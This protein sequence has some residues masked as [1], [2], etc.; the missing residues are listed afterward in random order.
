MKNSLKSLPQ[1]SFWL[2]LCIGFFISFSS[3][4]PENE[5]SIESDYGVFIGADSMNEKFYNYKIL[6][7][8]AANFT[9]ADLSLLHKKGIEVYS[10]LN[11]GSIENFR[12]YYSRF[13]PITLGPYENWPEERWVDLSRQEWQNYLIDTIAKSLV[14]KGIDGFFIDNLDIY[15]LFH[16]DHIF[17]GI[18]AILSGLRQSFPSKSILLNGGFDYTHALVQ[19]N[20]K[21]KKNKLLQDLA[22]GVNQECVFSSINFSQNLLTENSSKERKEMLDYLSFI[23]S[24][25]LEVYVIEYTRS[26]KLIKKIQNTFQEKGYSYYVTDNIDLQ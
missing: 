20:S 13:E 2:F 23:E 22:D 21:T 19:Q 5:S 16:T 12:N 26:K 1:N 15:Q 14:D 4:K 8:D 10:Y 6:V 18:T 3:C 25:K 9:A 11:I 7:I 17:H 24:Q